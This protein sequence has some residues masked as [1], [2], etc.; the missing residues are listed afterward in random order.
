MPLSLG[1]SQTGTKMIERDNLWRIP[2]WKRT[3][4]EMA[5]LMDEAAQNEKEMTE[6]EQIE[7]DAEFG[8]YPDDDDYVDDDEEE[9]D[10]YE[11]ND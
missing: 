6:Q 5:Q 3:A 7:Y 9:E 4:T 11:N 2:P 10:C 8:Y 1:I